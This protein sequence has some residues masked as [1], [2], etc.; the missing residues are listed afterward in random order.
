M[1]WTSLKMTAGSWHRKQ[2]SPSFTIVPQRRFRRLHP[3]NPRLLDGHSRHPRL[4]LLGCLGEGRSRLWLSMEAGV[5]VRQSQAVG[6][7]GRWAVG[8][9]IT[10]TLSTAIVLSRRDLGRSWRAVVRSL[11]CLLLK[12]LGRNLLSVKTAAMRAV[13]L[14]TEVVEE[15]GMGVVEVQVDAMVPTPVEF[16]G[17]KELQVKVPRGVRDRL[18][19]AAAVRG[20]QLVVQNIGRT[21]RAQQTRSARDKRC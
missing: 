19:L 11:R 16:V 5:R 10:N 7:G 1:T 6:A 3:G 14:E 12:W 13:G 18:G 15:S 21:V 8:V 9:V 2:Q 17:R 4:I 20:R